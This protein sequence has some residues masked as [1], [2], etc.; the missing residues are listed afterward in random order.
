MT[1]GITHL[2]WVVMENVFLLAAKISVRFYF[3]N[4]LA[5]VPDCIPLLP[6]LRR[7]GR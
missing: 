6:A 7:L 5:D 4:F 2:C 1:Q 3:E